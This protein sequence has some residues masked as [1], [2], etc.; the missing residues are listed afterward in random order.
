M[1]IYQALKSARII[2][3]INIS[4]VH[5]TYYTAI[6]IIN[7]THLRGNGGGG[8]EAVESQNESSV[9]AKQM[10]YYLHFV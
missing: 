8:F 1:I 2:F 6:G 4:Y 5:R 3:H 9:M 7:W 10:S